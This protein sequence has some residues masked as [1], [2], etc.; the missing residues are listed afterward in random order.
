MML[1]LSSLLF[2]YEYLLHLGFLR[3]LRFAAA[4]PGYS[5]KAIPGEL[6]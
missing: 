2:Y 6:A 5:L 4:S 3:A 1:A